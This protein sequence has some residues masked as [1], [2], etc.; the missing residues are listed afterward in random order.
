[1]YYSKLIENTKSNV[2]DTWNV[3][4]NI[5]NNNQGNGNNIVDTVMYDNN[6]ISDP[7]RISNEFNNFFV[8]VGPSL[9]SSI[10][11]NNGDVF[12]YL[13]SRNLN[14]IFLGSITKC[15][16][17]SVVK[18]LG[19]KNSNDYSGLSMNV[20]KNVILNIADLTFTCNV[21]LSLLAIFPKE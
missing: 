11:C 1:M 8:E 17:I 21:S 16:I 5:I 12:Y 7:C 19:S 15:D 3:L 6:V 4:R 14:S 9:A 2:K 18:D 10:P 13:G 20:I